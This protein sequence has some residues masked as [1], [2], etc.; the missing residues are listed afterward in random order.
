MYSKWPECKH[1]YKQNILAIEVKHTL[2]DDGASQFHSNLLHQLF[3]HVD[4]DCKGSPKFAAIDTATE[5][6]F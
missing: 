1:Y 2:I 6:I 5:V 4:R 3:I